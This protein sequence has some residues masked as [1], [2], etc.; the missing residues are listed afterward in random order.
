MPLLYCKLHEMAFDR[1]HNSWVH[2]PRK[3][4]TPLQHFYHWLR[5]ANIE[6]PEY[7]VVEVPCDQCSQPSH[8]K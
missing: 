5:S 1:E 6:S 8:E 2:F 4:I 3:D 7:E